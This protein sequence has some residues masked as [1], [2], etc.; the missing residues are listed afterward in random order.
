MAREVHRPFFALSLRFRTPF[1]IFTAYFVFLQC[2]GLLPTFF[3]LCF[4][5]KF[6][7]RGIQGLPTPISIDSIPLNNHQSL[8]SSILNLSKTD[9]LVFVSRKSFAGSPNSK[10]S[11]RVI[12]RSTECKLDLPF[13]T[14]LPVSFCLILVKN[15]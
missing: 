14:I 15:D 7:Q 6:K 4:A 2:P 8:I 12:R 10:K 9:F 1:A 11:R 3:L 13:A 5:C